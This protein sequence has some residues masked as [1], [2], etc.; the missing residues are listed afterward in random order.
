MAPLPMAK[1]YDKEIAICR[2]EHAT[3]R[4]EAEIA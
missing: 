3:L 1:H 2:V 4:G